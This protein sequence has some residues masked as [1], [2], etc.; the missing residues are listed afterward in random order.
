MSQFFFFFFNFQIF[1]K[2]EMTWNKNLLFG[3]H[4]EMK[5]VL[6]NMVV[7]FSV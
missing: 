5:D 6:N 1:A 4:F 2:I 3:R 7:V